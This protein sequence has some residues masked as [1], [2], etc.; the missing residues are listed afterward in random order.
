M[1]SL[2]IVP[3]LAAAITAIQELSREIDELR[4]AANLPAKTRTVAPVVDDARVINSDTP[5]RR[6][7]A[8]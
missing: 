3:M 6:A 7:E 2:N 5:S 4:A 1:Y 8:E